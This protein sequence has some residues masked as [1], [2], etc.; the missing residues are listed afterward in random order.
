MLCVLEVRTTAAVVAQPYISQQSLSLGR[1]RSQ[2][3]VRRSD[4]YA[5]SGASSAPPFTASR[6][7]APTC[8]SSD[9][10]HSSRGGI[11][12]P[13]MSTASNRQRSSEVASG[14][15]YLRDVAEQP[16]QSFG[17]KYYGSLLKGCVIYRVGNFGGVDNL[18]KLG[19]E[20]LMALT[21]KLCTSF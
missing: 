19:K 8:Q 10:V 17:I 15:A 9:T 3:Y 2:L 18:C 6:H 4:T 16:M 7:Q 5:Y 12:L 1:P 14:L 11:N 21:C 13:P 20:Y